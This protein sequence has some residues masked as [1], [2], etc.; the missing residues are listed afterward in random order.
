MRILLKGLR[1][2]KI[3][4][5]RNWRMFETSESSSHYRRYLPANTK[6]LDIAKEQRQRMVEGRAL[7]K[8]TFADFKRSF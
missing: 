1:I 7:F 8:H 3:I 4:M 2:K 5:F 6:I